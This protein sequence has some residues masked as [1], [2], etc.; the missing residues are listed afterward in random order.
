MEEFD[1]EFMEVALERNIIGLMSDGLLGSRSIYDRKD[2][3][4]FL[5]ANQEEEENFQKNLTEKAT[6]F[7]KPY[8]G[9]KIFLAVKNGDFTPGL[10]TVINTCYMLSID[11]SIVT[12]TD[13]I[14]GMN[15]FQSVMYK[16][17]NE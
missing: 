6:K 5:E 12:Y 10:I 14:N 11:L 16:T 13:R 15:C 3:M 17:K 9:K 8:E 7:L 4:D 1:I 2:E